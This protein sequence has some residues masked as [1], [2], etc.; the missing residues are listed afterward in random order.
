MTHLDGLHRGKQQN[1]VGDTLSAF[2]E[3]SPSYPSHHILL[4]MSTLRLAGMDSGVAFSK[5][6]DEDVLT[7]YADTAEKGADK[8]RQTLP[9]L[10]VYIYTRDHHRPTTPRLRSRRPDPPVQP[11]IRKSPRSSS[12]HPLL[13]ASKRMRAAPA[14]PVV[15]V[16]ALSP[17]WRSLFGEALTPI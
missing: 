16:V 13:Q 14:A 8:V 11:E 1:N 4:N 6:M 2:A 9:C 7:M 17:S 12:A 10:Y 3:V 5:T 15:V